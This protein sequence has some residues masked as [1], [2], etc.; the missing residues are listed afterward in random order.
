MLDAT[1]IFDGT[2]PATGIA[3]TT[4][5]ASTNVLDF[6]VGRDIGAGNRLMLNVLVTEAFT[7]GGAG[8]L[9]IDLETSAEEGAN[10]EVLISSGP[11]GVADLILGARYGFVLP[12]NQVRNATAGVLDFPGQYY[13]LNYTVGTGPMLT[14][15]VMAW[16][17]AAPDREAFTNYPR[18]YTAYVADDQIAV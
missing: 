2:L 3:I 16:L 1:Q 7:A 17:T 10:Y 5:R 12:Q 13:R 18:N 15:A 6:L 14:G 9:T 11:I 4:T 8:T